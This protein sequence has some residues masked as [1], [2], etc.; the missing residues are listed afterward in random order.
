MELAHRATVLTVAKAVVH[1]AAETTA[2]RAKARLAKALMAA[3]TLV[4]RA[5]VHPAKD[6]AVAVVAM[7]AATVMVAVTNVTMQDQN[8]K[9][10]AS[11]AAVSFPHHPKMRLQRSLLQICDLVQPMVGGYQPSAINCFV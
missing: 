1:P 9:D 4:A 7:V 10:T 6:R 3:R 11:T 5:A 2:A 8:G